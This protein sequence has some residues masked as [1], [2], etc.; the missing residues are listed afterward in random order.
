ME[1]GR[2]DVVHSSADAL[3]DTNDVESVSARVWQAATEN[4]I[5]RTAAAVR[6]ERIR[7][8]MTPS[9]S[10]L[11]VVGERPSVLPMPVVSKVRSRVA[12]TQGR[13]RTATLTTA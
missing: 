7:T 5:D 13:L 11:R 1:V 9:R 6:R 4:A 10:R 2:P 8:S 12:R 3:P